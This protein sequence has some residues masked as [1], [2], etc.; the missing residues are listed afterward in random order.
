[1]KKVLL[2]LVFFVVSATVGAQPPPPPPPVPPPPG[3][4]TPIDTDVLYFILPAALFAVYSLNK[5]RAG[6]VT[7]L[8]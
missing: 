8:K 1:M 2:L 7:D 4:S 3:T 6:L 5:K